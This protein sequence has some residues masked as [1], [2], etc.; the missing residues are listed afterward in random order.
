MKT[1]FKYILKYAV[2]GVMEDNPSWAQVLTSLVG[3]FILFFITSF[4]IFAL[5]RFLIS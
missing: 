2:L 3:T 5:L 1:T 4:L